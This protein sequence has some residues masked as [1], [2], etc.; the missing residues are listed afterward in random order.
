MYCYQITERVRHGLPVMREEGFPVIPTPTGCP[1]RLLLADSMA[2]TIRE[3]P[4][5]E[6]R[7][8]VKDGQVVPMDVEFSDKHILFKRRMYRSAKQ[9]LVRVETYA[10]MDGKVM[11]TASS[12]D[13]RMAGNQQNARVRRVYKPFP[14]DG[15][16]PLCTPNVVEEA[17]KGV[18]FL[19]MFVMLYP[20][21]SFR[22]VRNGKLEGA[23]PWMQV[24]WNGYDLWCATKVCLEGGLRDA[25]RRRS[26]APTS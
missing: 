18:P 8:G 17:C 1:F 4:E 11:L 16:V 26:L 9:A 22:I 3:L 2:T 21:A 23:S 25:R 7:I 10:G 20:G 6:L 24:N 19:D 14:D 13:N 15:V 5:G 12:F